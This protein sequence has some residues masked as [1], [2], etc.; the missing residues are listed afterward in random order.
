M[1]EI[2]FMKLSKQHKRKTS[3]LGELPNRTLPLGY[4][5]PTSVCSTVAITELEKSQGHHVSDFDLRGICCIDLT[6]LHYSPHLCFLIC[7]M[8]PIFSSYLSGV[9]D[10]CCAINVYIQCLLHSGRATYYS[11][12]S[13]LQRLRGEHSQ[14]WL[15]ILGPPLTNRWAGHITF[16]SPKFLIYILELM[17]PVSRSL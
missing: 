6:T 16:R 9:L 4:S 13:H 1:Y 10:R 12:Y 8:E 15:Q 17:V 5:L 7:R 11:K 3:P 14:P 2:S